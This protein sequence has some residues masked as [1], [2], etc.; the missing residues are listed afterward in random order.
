MTWYFLVMASVAVAA[1]LAGFCM[2]RLTGGND[3]VPEIGVEGTGG[4]KLGRGRKD[5]GSMEPG[6][7]QIGMHD[8]SRMAVAGLWGKRDGNTIQEGTGWKGQASMPAGTGIPGGTDAPGSAGR[9]D[10]SGMPDAV[11]MP[12][13]TGRPAGTGMSGSTDRLGLTDVLGSQPVGSLSGTALSGRNR[14]AR[15]H[16]G[17]YQVR[18][19]RGRQVVEEACTWSVGS[20]V[21]GEVAAVYEGECPAVQI[22][23]MEDRLCAPVG[24]KVVH[25]FPMGNGLLFRTDFGT[26]LR[27]Q[28]GNSQDELL[29]RHYRPRVVRNEIVTKGK[30]LLQFDRKGLVAEGVSPMV[31]VSVSHCAYGSSV[32]PTSSQ[33]VDSGEEILKVQGIPE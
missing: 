7:D 17:L 21:S 29:G 10:A 23:P 27:I 2:G 26:E 16:P 31:T 33:W 15:N 18:R 25:L 20:P 9:L 13:G 6:Q 12:A 1:V 4:L 30:V 5:A 11:R 32:Q 8:R 3:V 14:V 28:V 19:N 22:L 24:G